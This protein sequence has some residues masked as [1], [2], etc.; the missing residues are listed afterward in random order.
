MYVITAIDS[1]SCGLRD[2]VY[3]SV[4]QFPLQVLSANSVTLCDNSSQGSALAN[5]AGGTPFSNG[6]YNFEWYNTNWG[7]VGVG[8]SISNLAIGDYFLE[9][10]DANGCQA[11]MPI[12]VSTPQLPLFVSPQLFG[13]VCTGDASGSAIVFTLSL[14]HI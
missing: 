12:T 3:I 4:P 2:T 8:D 6:S 14:I 1:D 7:S 11:N 13:V 5:A 10:T 9:V